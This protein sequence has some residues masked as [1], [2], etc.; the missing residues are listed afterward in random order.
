VV[1]PSIRGILRGLIRNAIAGAIPGVLVL[2]VAS[3]A[4]A[5][6]RDVGRQTCRVEVLS[7]E[8][9]PVGALFYHTVR[10]TLSITSPGDAPVVRDVEGMIPWQAPPPR[11]GQKMRVACDA[12]GIGAALGLK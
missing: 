7:S 4:L 11:Q 8:E 3:E 5:R 12:A 6:T 2:D 1:L 9:L 10:A